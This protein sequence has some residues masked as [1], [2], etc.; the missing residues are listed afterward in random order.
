[1]INFLLL[2]LLISVVSVRDLCM[3]ICVTMCK[4]E[5]KFFVFVFC[6]FVCFLFFCF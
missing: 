2:V 6:V 4:K 3:Y 5:R 1:M